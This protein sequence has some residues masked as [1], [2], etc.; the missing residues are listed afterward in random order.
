MMLFGRLKYNLLVDIVII[1][2]IWVVVFWNFDLILYCKVINVSYKV[3]V[4]GVMLRIE[5]IL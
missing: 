4:V 3:F 2:L 5:I 1:V